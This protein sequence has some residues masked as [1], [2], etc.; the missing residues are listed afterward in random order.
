MDRKR[1]FIFIGEVMVISMLACQSITRPILGPQVLST[2]SAQVPTL[3][4]VS[5]EDTL[6]L[7]FNFLAEPNTACA[8]HKGRALS[9]LDKDGWHVYKWDSLESIAQ[10]PDGRIYLG[11][12]KKV[13]GRQFGVKFYIQKDNTLFKE[14]GHDGSPIPSADYF[15]CGPENEIWTGDWSGLGISHFD[16]TTWTDYYY[17]GGFYSGPGNMAIAVAPS[18]N[19][20]AVSSPFMEGGSIVTFDG[21]NWQIIRQLSPEWVSYP[22]GGFYSYPGFH[23]LAIDAN[24]N[25]WVFGDG[26]EKYDG[27]QWSTFPAPEGFSGTVMSYRENRVW[28]ASQNTIYS[29]DPQTNSWT[30][31]FGLE[32][33][34][35]RSVNVMQFDR[36]GRLWVATDYGLY[37]YDG[38]VW[39]TYH[40]Y[41][42]DL[43]ANS[44]D[45]II[46]F[47]DGPQLTA[48]TLKAPGSVR[49]KVVNPN[50]PVYENMQV[51]VCLEP[52]IVSSQET[53]PC[54]DQ[55]YHALTTMD[56]EG[57]F[58]FTNIPVGR[59]YLMIQIS[60][61]TWSRMIDP[62][63]PPSS[64]GAEFE[65]KPGAETQ[66][67]EI[68]PSPESN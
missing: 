21:T 33:L 68:T 15:A 37:I 50:S 46:I 18:G 54:A 38:S 48:L 39:T 47:G 22:G 52:V 17:P 42:A 5:E 51:E 30:L 28:M 36:Q 31:E 10:C 25:V 65:V 13:V 20:W 4:A 11:I 34:S 63:S 58:L 57:N 56:A 12:G 41:T 27:V 3:T 61:S 55:A 14:V 32:A 1:M 16:G 7:P 66:L 2:E 35:G 62:S 67:G 19:L 44:V 26:L 53:T 6:T 64:L 59:Y 29:F 24:G 9:C 43:Y 45:G 40:T 60:S 49:G 23:G 8:I